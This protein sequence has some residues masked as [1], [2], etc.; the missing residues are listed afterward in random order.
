MARLI[1]GLIVLVCLQYVSCSK[2]VCYFT[3]WS[4]YRPAAGRFTPENVDPHLCTHLIY[5]FSILQSN[6]LTTYEWNDEVLYKQFNGLK[7]KNPELKTLLAVG[8]WNFGSTPFTIM[9]SSPANRQTFIQSAI[10]FLRLHEF[11]GL[12]LDWEYPGARGS[13]P[14]DK[15]RFTVLCQELIAAF[16]KEATETGQP[17]LLL[18]AAVAAGKGTIDNGYEIAQVTK[19]LDFVNVMS[20]DFHGAWDP[21]TGHN[22]PLFRSSG[23]HDDNIYYN[24]DFTMK[25]WR[26]QGAPVE[27]LLVGLATYGRTFRISSPSHSLGA[28]ASGPAP[29]GAYTREAGSWSY[30]EICLFLRGGS[31]NWIDEQKVPYA[32]QGNDWVGFDNKQSFEIKVDYLKRNN[33]G[34]AF[35][36]ALDLDDF[37]G[38]FCGQGAYPLINHV[39]SLL[40][41]DFP[42]P[43]PEVTVAPTDN[44]EETTT[45]TTTIP[46]TAAPT[47]TA[48]PTTAA[49]S[50][51]TT[52]HPTT[53]ATMTTTTTTTTVSGSAF[54]VGKESGLYANNENKNTYYQCSNGL[55]Y[56]MRCPASLVF[57]VRC[58]C[59]DW[60]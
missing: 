8:G 50:T 11:D 37:S 46:T 30:Y 22:S 31:L 24:V 52:A 18:T 28:P 56:L 35:I 33:F 3:N 16:E 59:C 51:T 4:Q 9:V 34:G 21:F 5:A 29:A 27:K 53:A 41:T 58:Q 39:R 2:L 47:V 1:T 49:P 25:F 48:I 57:N 55:T 26:D 36:W 6:Q 14:E 15:H 17:R 20:Y 43:T 42:V 23:D 60:P 40:E 44:T 32:I 19:L 7:N 10:R 54:C 12:D 38:Q 13:P 45:P